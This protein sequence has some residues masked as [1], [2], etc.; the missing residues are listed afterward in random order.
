[1]RFL[2]GAEWSGAWPISYDS[3]AQWPCNC[4]NQAI[5][6]KTRIEGSMSVIAIYRQLPG[7]GHI[8][9]LMNRAGLL[10]AMLVAGCCTVLSAQQGRPGQK[11][12]HMFTAPDGTF[13]FSYSRALVLCR[14]NPNQTNRWKPDNSCNAYTAVCSDFSCDSS[15][16]VACIAYPA[17]RMKGTNFEAAAF[18]VNELKKVVAESEC[19]KLDEPPPHRNV[20]DE[21]V[22][23]ITFKVAESDGIA[24]GN[25]IDGHVYRTFHDGKCYELDIRIAS[26]NIAN[27]E[28]GSVKSFDLGKVQRTLKPAVASF[29]FLK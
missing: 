12:S 26:S 8:M 21:T 28:S 27:H 18:S 19:I 20:K 22:N 1:M 6:L 5:T 15:G 13:R 17:N 9:C 4:C 3:P 7:S 29:T 2:A 10:I 25:F 14:K 23:G 11:S 24:A 16:T